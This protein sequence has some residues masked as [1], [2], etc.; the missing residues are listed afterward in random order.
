MDEGAILDHFYKHSETLHNCTKLVVVIIQ[1]IIIYIQE[2]IFPVSLH[3]FTALFTFYFSVLFSIDVMSIVV[4][5]FS[6]SLN[7]SSRKLRM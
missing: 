4:F 6:V 2:L 3:C 7:Y 1:G 5:L